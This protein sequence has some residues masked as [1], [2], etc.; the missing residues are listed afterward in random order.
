MNTYTSI[1]GENIVKLIGKITYKEVNTY[2]DNLNFRCKLAVPIE[3]RFQYI[4]ITAW[5]K[6]AEALSELP[7]NSY[8]KLFGH[9]EES[10]YEV[11]CKYCNGPSKA[12]WTTIVVD[13]FVLL[14]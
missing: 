7:N 2:G 11:K 6:L 12:Y 9:I 4:K 1:L 5:G 10:S 8:I 13:N 14:N 3:E